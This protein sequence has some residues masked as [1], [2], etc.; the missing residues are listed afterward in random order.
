MIFNDKKTLPCW[1]KQFPQPAI[2][3]RFFHIDLKGPKIPVHILSSLL[4]QIARWGINGVVVE[5]EHR[6]PYL[7]LPQQFPAYDRYKKSEIESLLEKAE[8]LGIEWIPLVQTFG[9]VEYLSRIKGTED[10]FE[11]KNYPSQLCPSK[12]NVKEYIRN[13]IDYIC[14]LHPKSRYIHVGQDETHQLGFCPQCSKRMKKFRD[15]MNLY[16]DHVMF[17]WDEVFKHNRIP[18]SWGDMFAGYGRLDL[19]EKVDKRVI[20][21]PW[22]YTSVDKTSKS[23]VYKGF[24]PSKKQF[25]NKYTEPEP[26]L[27]FV[28]SGQFFEDLDEEDIKKIGVGENEYPLGCGQIRIMAR[29]G[30]PVWGTCAVY[31]SADMQLH[32]NYIRGFLNPV[33][34]CDVI[35]SLGG[36][37]I[38]GTLWARGH[39]FAP[40]NAPWT[41]SLYNIAQFAAGSWTGKRSPED[42]KK[43]ADEISYEIDM[44]KSFDKEWC[45]DDILWTV[46]APC[47]SSGLY[48]KIETLDNILE[49]LKKQDIS[50]CFG[51][52]LNLTLEAENIQNN[53]RYILEEAR[54]WYSTRK[55]MPQVMKQDMR[56]RIQRFNSDIKRLKIPTEKYYLKWVGDKK[57]FNLWWENLFSLDIRI[58]K[59]VVQL[60][61]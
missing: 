37:G 14:E 23:V 54:W 7:P 38:I 39:S 51:E 31:I 4:E 53:L 15:R 16:F 8:S 58:A 12:E 52:G 61:K 26:L 55:E 48:S 20:L 44:P 42:L 34:M 10:L 19:V 33:Q 59:E 36:D 49:I 35:T 5:Y 28:K 21:L 46:S 41:L 43:I 50:G 1:R 24:R 60:L 29:T 2:K 25:Y 47:S 22:D 13:L 9:H 3:N 17:V 57:S 45:L 6:L 40:I 56:K 11:N 27:T 18:M 30:R 32:A